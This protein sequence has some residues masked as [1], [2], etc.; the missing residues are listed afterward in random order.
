MPFKKEMCFAKALYAVWSPH[1]A[2]PLI[3]F[4]TVC[5]IAIKLSFSRKMPTFY[6]RKGVPNRGQWTEESLHKAMDAVRKK[7]MGVN[8]ASRSFGVPKT[9]LKRRLKSNNVIKKSLGPPSILGE[10]NERKIVGHIKKLQKYGF[11]PTRNSVRSMAFHLAERLKLNH[12]FDRENQMAGYDWLKSFLSRNPDLTIRKAEGVSVARALGM[13]KDSVKEYFD[14]LKKLMTENHL[15]EKP[16][17]IFNM[18]ETGLP[19]N[20]KPG[21]V[22]AEKGSRN[23]SLITS[24]EKGETISV[25]T[26]VN[27]EGSFLPPYCILKGKNTKDEYADGMPP[28]SVVKMSQKSAYVNSEIFFDW[29]RNH[30]TPRKPQGI[31]I[32]ILD[33]HTSHT[34]SS[35]MLEYAESNGIILLSLPSHT[36]HWLQPLDRVFFKSLKSYYIKA[37]NNFMTNHPSRKLTRLQFGEMLSA[38]WNKSASVEN[39]VSAFKSTGIIPFNPNVIPEYAFLTEVNGQ[40]QASK[41]A[42][43][44]AVGVH[45]DK[46]LAEG[47]PEN[48]RRPLPETLPEDFSQLP[49]TSRGSNAVTSLQEDTQQAVENAEEPMAEGSKTHSLC[50]RL[51]KP[52]ENFSPLPGTS[53]RSRSVTSPVNGS[54]SISISNN[55]TR[56]VVTPSHSPQKVTSEQFTPS[57]MLCDISPVPLVK[58]PNVGKRRGKPASQAKFLNSPEN[59]AVLKEKK[60]LQ[61]MNQEK[62]LKNREERERKQNAIKSMQDL[63]AEKRK[64]NVSDRKGKKAKRNPSVPHS[65]ES[66]DDFPVVYAESDNSEPEDWNENECVGCGEDYNETTKNEEWFQCVLCHRWLH[67]GCSQYDH[68]CHGCGKKSYKKV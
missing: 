57:K 2:A 26:C 67:E 62:K 47:T 58:K 21:E 48:S 35:E 64:M 23:V 1:Q 42:Q 4:D 40:T 28:G 10:V 61:Q 66:D 9:T 44:A 14:L 11:A 54:C 51:E 65:S 13:N 12:K 33:G 20:N 3:D 29:L 45:A 7:E 22:I 56:K 63:T 30:F 50:S 18:D 6:Q 27:G 17:H 5:S 41:E 46:P 37:C 43:P 16:G 49:G 52:P 15:L 59:V 31:V 34:S 53:Q 36:T 8:E 32:L 68:M 39:G 19:L 25:L 55:E 24:G 60:K 38:A